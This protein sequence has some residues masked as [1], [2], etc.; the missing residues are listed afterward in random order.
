[1]KLPI[2]IQGQIIA[3]L[4]KFANCEDRYAYG[5]LAYLA[6]NRDNHDLII[7]GGAI[8]AASIQ[9]KKEADGKEVPSDSVSNSL[10]LLQN[11]FIY[12]SADT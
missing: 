8:E 10:R 3:D 6:V 11:L 4:C 9:L 2:D 1:V 12:G 5:C 7:S